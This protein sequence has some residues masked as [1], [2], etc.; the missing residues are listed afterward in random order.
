MIEYFGKQYVPIQ[1]DFFA[2][3]SFEV[4][5]RLVGCVLRMDYRGGDVAIGLSDLEAYD[6]IEGAFHGA[7]SQRLADGH[8]YVHPYRRSKMWAIDLVCGPKG[9]GSSVLIRAGIP[10]LG[11]EIMAARRSRDPAADRIVQARAKGYEKRIAHGPCA[12]GETLDI[13]PALDGAWL[14]EKPFRIYRPVEP[15]TDID[16][17][18]RLNITRDAELPWRSKWRNPPLPLPAQAAA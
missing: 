12:V 18:R 13:Q 6:E 8:A 10:L 15:I 17:G 5:P 1:P 16:I 4:A 9:R 2:P 7:P 11:L 14:F 3:P